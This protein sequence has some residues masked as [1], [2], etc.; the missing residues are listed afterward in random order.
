MPKYINTSAV[1]LLYFLLL[2]GCAS[3]LNKRTS[4]KYYE[5]ASRSE[6]IG[7]FASAKESYRRALINAKM[8]DA[9]PEAISAV[10]YGFGK[11]QGYTCDYEA[12]D[13]TLRESIS[14]EMALPHPEQINLTQRYSELARLAM[15][16]RK[17]SEAVGYFQ[18]AIPLMEPMNIRTSDPIG[19][20]KYLDDYALVLSEVGDH[21]TS[22]EIRAQSA[23]LRMKNP[24]VYAKFIPRYYQDACR[25]NK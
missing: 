23:E 20:A 16:R 1:Y 18:K 11:M 3:E 4:A 5:A 15:A 7:D 2:S 22:N 25:N 10:M 19:F 14:L 21:Q 12:G 13:Q 17:P 24:G 8:G 9:P 6:A